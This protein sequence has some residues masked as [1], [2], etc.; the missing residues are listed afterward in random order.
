VIPSTSL[1]IGKACVHCVDLLKQLIGNGFPVHHR[2]VRIQY[3]PEFTLKRREIDHFVFAFSPSS[4]APASSSLRIAADLVSCFDLA[5][6]DRAD[7][8]EA[9]I[10][11]W[12]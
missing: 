10:V 7:K 9:C 6:V 12:L 5:S 8:S 4:T 1:I 3:A 2:L 11:A